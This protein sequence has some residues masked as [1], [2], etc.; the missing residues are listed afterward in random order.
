[1][2]TPRLDAVRRWGDRLG[3][4]GRWWSSLGT[5]CVAILG[6]VLL[7]GATGE[8]VPPEVRA[9]RFVLTDT[10]GKTRAEL[11]GE[12]DG[13][14]ALRLADRNG[15]VRARLSVGADGFPHLALNGADGRPRALLTAK[16]DD[17][18]NLVF[19]DKWGKRRLVL[20]VGLGGWSVLALADERGDDRAVLQVAPDGT[21]VLVFFDKTGKVS[22]K[23][24]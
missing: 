17:W 11:W 22:W 21:P 12:P 20:D 15:V 24:P 4:V 14:I 9:K 16:P 5:A 8:K 1:M 10:D 7:A 23:A 13:S 3:R 19:F 18:P 2:K 6:L